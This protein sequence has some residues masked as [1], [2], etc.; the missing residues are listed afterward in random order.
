MSATLEHP[1]VMDKPNVVRAT[2]MIR[3]RSNLHAPSFAPFANFPSHQARNHLSNIRR[4][5]LSAPDRR[6][7]ARTPCL[8]RRWAH[9]GANALAAFPNALRYGHE[10]GSKHA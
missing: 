9:T 10:G 3:L 5:T 8:L 1:Q 2:L 6:R 7:S 4:A